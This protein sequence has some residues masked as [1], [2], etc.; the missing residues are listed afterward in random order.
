MANSPSGGNCSGIITDGGYNLN[1]DA[2]GNTCGFATANNSLPNTWPAPWLGPLADNG[3]PTKTHALQLPS[4]AINAVPQGANGCATDITTDQRGIKRPQGG[5]CEIGSFEDESPRVK[6][7]VPQ[8][9]TTGVAQGANIGAFFCEA[10][11]ADF[12]NAKTVILFKAGTTTPLAAVVSYDAEKKKATLNPNANLKRGT[13]Y[14]AVV[15]TGAQ[16]LAGNRLNQDLG[17]TGNQKKVWSFT[18]RN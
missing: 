12:V 15:T 9:G 10:L 1:S 3:G 11:T 6:R 13:R 17:V 18:V 4:P 5:K 14:K 16:D 7:V 2:A 8:Q